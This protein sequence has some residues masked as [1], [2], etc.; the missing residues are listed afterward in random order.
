[1]AAH[2]SY[3]PR[4]AFARD[5]LTAAVDG[6]SSYW[7]RIWSYRSDCPPDQV[8]AVGVDTEDGQSL[9]HVS[10]DDIQAAIDNVADRPDTCGFGRLDRRWR[11]RL[12]EL[13][14]SIRDQLDAGAYPHSV[15]D[16]SQI[17]AADAD[18][19]LQVAMA[20]QVIYG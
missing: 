20:E 3:T 9:F 8:L 14:R 12:P 19:I 7:A 15:Y 5:I 1:M 18:L 16:T 17:D 11:V 13:L 6:G 4:Q 10:L 2:R